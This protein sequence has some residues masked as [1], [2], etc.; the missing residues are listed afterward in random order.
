MADSFDKVYG[1]RG[2]DT[3]YER[4]QITYRPNIA[5]QKEKIRAL[6]TVETKQSI[7]RARRFTISNNLSEYDELIAELEQMLKDIEARNDAGL[8]EQLKS[9]LA[10]E[11]YQEVATF[12]STNTGYSQ[13]GDF[14]LYT[15]L[16][17][18]KGSLNTRRG[19]IDE[20][21]RTQITSETEIDLITEAEI[22]S[23]DNWELLEAQVM[24]GYSELGH[25]EDD[26]EEVHAAEDNIFPDNTEI[27]YEYLESLEK[28]KRSSEL[29]HTTL[30][31]TSYVHTN[32]YY[33][34]LSLIEKM[35]VLV[36]YPT[37]LVDK[38]LKTFIYMLQ[39]L[40][41]IPAA[42]THLILSYK[43]YKDQ[44][45]SLKGKMLTIDDEK[46]TFA[47]EKQYLY[48][49]L[50]TKA[51]EPIKS[52]LYEQSDEVSGAMDIFAGYMVSSI[53][54]STETYDNSLSDMLN[55]YQSESDFYEKQIY[56]LKNKEEIRRFYSILEDLEDAGQVQ[57]S[58]VE[59]YLK[60]NGYSV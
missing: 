17:M 47:S 45:E 21:F 26:D 13:T 43:T 15:V 48:Q 1:S 50:Q 22:A 10:A 8:M 16:Y 52:W 46:E 35:R 3:T 11:S 39:D 30:S 18:M 34:F 33:L 4:E 23:I 58:W 49:Q 51:T 40:S 9:L 28:Q 14:E 24:Q 55:F 32:R 57:T 54:K 53:T 25:H 42:K 60:A 7:E 37:T 6:L 31:D 5:Y 41:N 20:R 2:I 19:F 59:E 12:E 27:S 44:H 38:D 36:Y 29:L 56:F